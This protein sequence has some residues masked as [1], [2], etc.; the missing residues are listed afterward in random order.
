[1][2]NQQDRRER[3][4]ALVLAGIYAKA[5]GGTGLDWFEHDAKTAVGAADALIAELDRTAPSKPEQPEGWVIWDD[6]DWE[7]PIQ[8]QFLW[9]G[10]RVEPFPTEAEAR[11]ALGQYSTDYGLRVRRW[12]LDPSEDK[13]V[14][15]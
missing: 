10:L 3:I 7:H 11:Q 5:Q 12:P 13:E 8:D 15:Q 6:S 9:H 14:H 1:M 2:G 4:A